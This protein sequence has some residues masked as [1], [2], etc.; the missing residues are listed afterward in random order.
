MGFWGDSGGREGVEGWG[1]SGGGGWVQFLVQQEERGGPGWWWWWGVVG[2]ALSQGRVVGGDAAARDMVARARS[3]WLAGCH[4]STPNVHPAP[5]PNS[6][7]K[8]RIRKRY[9]RE[10]IK[11]EL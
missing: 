8:E 2:A 11:I 4:L 7:I 3:A 9:E 10:R 6:E 5:P 1:R